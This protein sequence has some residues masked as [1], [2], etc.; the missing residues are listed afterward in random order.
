MNR[1]DPKRAAAALAALGASPAALADAG[2]MTPT[3][4]ISLFAVPVV[5]A[6]LYVVH[7]KLS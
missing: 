2:G 5:I 1:F 4:W 6:I 3:G 7:K